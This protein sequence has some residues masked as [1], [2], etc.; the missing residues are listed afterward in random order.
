MLRSLPASGLALLALL[1]PLIAQ[2]AAPAKPL[3]I[4]VLYA[5]DWRFDTLGVAGHPVV[6]TPALD[7]LAQEGMRFTRNCVTTA[8]CGVSRATLL[9][10][11][12]MSRHGN[13]AFAMFT[14]PW[15]ETYPGRLRANGYHVGHIGKWHN[16]PFPKE[17]FDFGRSYSGTH[18]I[19]EA[20]GTKIHVTQKN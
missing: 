4:V 11:Q 20:D 6:Q 2:A 12:W 16:G 1:S 14:T 13:P 3:N 19:K 7:R 18:W 8:I 15:A 17:N 10:G 5:D 9:T